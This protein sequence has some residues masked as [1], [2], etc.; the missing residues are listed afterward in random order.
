MKKEK[1]SVVEQ[2]E[3]IALPV[4]ERLGLRLWDV[5]FVKEGASWFLRIYIDKEN[6]VSV[7]DCEAL[8]RAIDGPLDL[9][10]PIEHSYYLEVSSP[11]IERVLRKE[12]HFKASIGK[13]VKIRLIRPLQNGEKEIVGTLQGFQGEDITIDR[14][15][16]EFIVK[17][18][19]AA[20]VQ[21]YDEY[22]NI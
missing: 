16:E 20:R 7:D 11:G 17:R 15:G 21:I 9:A 4:A 10:D 18:S 2:V 12:E 22:I 3:K 8:S 13:P 5:E 1:G 14:G 6:G 19:D